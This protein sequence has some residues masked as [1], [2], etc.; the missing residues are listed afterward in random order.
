[1][2]IQID[3]FTRTKRRTIALIIERDGTLTVRAPLR[4]TRAAIE[5]FIRQKTDWILRTREKL[6]AVP[7][8]L[9]RKFVDG[10][11]FLYLGSPYNLKLVRPRRPALHFDDGFTLSLSA[12]K[13]GRQYFVRWYRERA[14]EVISARV[15]QYAR[16]HGFTPKQVRITSARTRW[17]SCSSTGTLSFTW[18]LVMAPLEVIDY[19]V[20]HELV[21]LRIRNHSLKFWQAVGALDP[22]Y[23]ARRKWLKENGEKLDL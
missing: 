7:P 14:F 23:G 20:L 13:K 15:D 19:V 1:M 10:E 11:S 9:E 6:K 22:G 21:H 8:A 16:I 12:Q 4:A 18:R 3:K 2:Q 5:A 17:G